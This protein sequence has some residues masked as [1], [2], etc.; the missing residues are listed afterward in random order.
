MSPNILNPP[1]PPPF[2][3]KKRIRFASPQHFYWEKVA[4]G[5]VPETPHTLKNIV[6]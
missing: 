6:N 3:N 2:Q 1:P 4:S 5:K